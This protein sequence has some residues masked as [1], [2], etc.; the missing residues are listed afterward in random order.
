MDH[1]RYG[2]WMRPAL[3]IDVAAPS[4]LAWEE[5]V[6]LANW[7]HWGPTVRGARLDDGSPL[8]SAGAT[9]SVQTPLGLWLP[10]R[11]DSYDDSGPHRSW[12]WRI[13]G[14]PATTH[15]VIEQGPSQCRI[16]MNVPLLAP[17]Y[18][19]VVAVALARI[20][21]RVEAKART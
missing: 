3:G 9:G 5:L 19:G 16:E 4:D 8:V 12:S 13:G 6:E 17:A 7:R 2:R 14:I 18:L 21:R 1:R 11:I 15:T 20:R 10:F